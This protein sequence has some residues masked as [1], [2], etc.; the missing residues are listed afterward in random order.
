[1]AQYQYE[2]KCTKCQSTTIF[3][4]TKNDNLQLCP[5]CNSMYKASI[6]VPSE[7]K[8]SPKTID[9][10][11]IHDTLVLRDLRKLKN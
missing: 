3:S 5:E 6:V 9:V 7:H 10:K 1:M 2:K 8:L 4:I 11:K